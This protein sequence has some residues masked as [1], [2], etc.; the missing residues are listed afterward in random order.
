MR[1][2]LKAALIAAWA[3][4]QSA[5]AQE[6]PAPDVAVARNNLYVEV[7]GPGFVGATLNYERLLAASETS[8]LRVRAGGGAWTSVFDGGGITL[9]AG[10][11]ACWRPGGSDRHALEVDLGMA[12]LWETYDGRLFDD[13]AA[14]NPYGGVGYRRQPREGGLVFRANLAIMPVLDIPVWPGFSFGAAF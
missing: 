3:G 7:A 9:G 12:P 8:E 2:T 6:P 14:V 11:N 10:M 1:N 13:L 4:V 5:N